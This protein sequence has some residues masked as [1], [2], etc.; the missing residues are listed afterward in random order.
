M[1]IVRSCRNSTTK[2]GAIP[3]PMLYG[4]EGTTTIPF[5]LVTTIYQV[6]TVTTTP[7]LKKKF[8]SNFIEKKYILESE[9]SEEL[10]TE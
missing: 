7:H 9:T 5:I 6:D 4:L 3:K 1:C 8:E 2:H 10:T